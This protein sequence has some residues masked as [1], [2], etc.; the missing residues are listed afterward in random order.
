[1]NRMHLFLFVFLT[2]PMIF[3]ER[4]VAKDRGEISTLNLPSD[5]I[6]FQ[7]A[8]GSQLANSYC[9]IC[10]SA[11]YIY[12]Q[13]P[14]PKEQWTEIV[15]KM[16]QSFGCP[17][18]DEQISPLVDYL[19]SQNSIQNSPSTHSTQPEGPNVIADQAQSSPGDPHKGKTLYDQHCPTCH[20]A[21][22]K[23]D[24]PIG[25]TLIP[26]AAN[27]TLLREKSDAA[28]LDTIRNGRPGTAMPS[29]K[30][31]LNHSELNDLLSFLRT[32]SP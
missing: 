10:H 7:S 13:P 21:G 22:G 14:H 29:W 25:Q 4:A 9:L 23:G 32:L 1:M 30:D 27:L 24:G 2:V 17:I 20:G 6:S 12:M 19:L 28:I 8:P 11:E 15:Q 18:P 26:P 5:P 16:N 31:Y 3:C